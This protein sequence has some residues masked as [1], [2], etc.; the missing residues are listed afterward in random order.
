MM[1][2]EDRMVG[3]G[4]G[5]S[6]GAGMDSAGGTGRGTSPGGAEDT[7]REAGDGAREKGRERTPPYLG[8]DGPTALRETAS[9]EADDGTPAD[10]SERSDDELDR[11][12]AEVAALDGRLVELIGARVGLARRI[13]TVK[14]ERSSLI[15]DPAQE[16]AVVRRAAE[17]ARRVAAPADDVRDLFW[18]LVALC[19]RVQLEEG[20]T[21]IVEDAR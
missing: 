20:S 11:L 4:S 15:V 19:R 2:A 6:R 5:R 16:A 12:R 13:G 1:D 17:T 3:R 18:R 7:R 9:S 8:E 14:R 10:A 21:P